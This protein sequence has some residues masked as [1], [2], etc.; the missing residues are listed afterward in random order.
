[1]IALW[2]RTQTDKVAY[3]KE[4]VDN[5]KAG[6]T[7]NVPIPST[8]IIRRGATRTAAGNTPFQGLGAVVATEALYRVTRDQM[9]GRMPGKACAFVHD[10]IISRC[11]DDR[12]D[13]LRAHQERVMIDAA[14]EIMPDIKMRVESVAMRHWAKNAKHKVIDGKLQVQEL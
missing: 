9:L 14:Q 12:V 7:Y 8:G 2:Y 10:E 6:S 13:E 3:L 4:Y 5:L 1:M 11:A